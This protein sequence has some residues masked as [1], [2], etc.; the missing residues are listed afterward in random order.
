MKIAISSTGRAPTSNVEAHFGR[1]PGFLIVDP[2]KGDYEYLDNSAVGSAHGAGIQAAQ[3]L[4]S[5][6]VNAVLSGNV[7][8]NAYGALTAAGIQVFTGVTGLVSEA[9]DRYAK[10]EFTNVKGPTVGGHF[11]TSGAGGSGRG[12][13][14]R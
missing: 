4:A 9:V 5:K 10:G 1:C 13:R 12:R 6:G 11:G 8:P 2:E 3:L 7:G 14:Q